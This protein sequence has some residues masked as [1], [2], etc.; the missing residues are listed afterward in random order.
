MDALLLTAEALRESINFYDTNCS[1]LAKLLIFLQKQTD[2]NQSR[3]DS[4]PYPKDLNIDLYLRNNIK[5]LNLIK[6][7]FN[8][9]FH[10]CIQNSWT[11]FTPETQ[12]SLNTI[13]EINNFHDSD[14]YKTYNYL[15]QETAKGTNTLP[16]YLF[17]LHQNKNG[18]TYEFIQDL[19][20][21]TDTSE[22]R[23]VLETHLLDLIRVRDI[24][25]LLLLE[26]EKFKKH[27]HEKYIPFLKQNSKFDVLNRF[28]NL[29][30]VSEFFGFEKPETLIGDQSQKKNYLKK[31]TQRP[32]TPL[33]KQHLNS[34]PEEEE[35]EEEEK[36][37]I[38]SSQ[39]SSFFSTLS[40]KSSTTEHDTDLAKVINSQ[41]PV[42]TDQ[43]SLFQQF[44]SRLPNLQLRNATS[45]PPFP[46]E[47]G[48]QLHPNDV[49]VVE[50]NKW[51]I[52]RLINKSRTEEL[53]NILETFLLAQHKERKYLRLKRVEAIVGKID[54][55]EKKQ[56]VEKAIQKYQV[57][58]PKKVVY[59]YQIQSRNSEEEV[60]LIQ[61]NVNNTEDISQLIES[62]LTSEGDID[63]IEVELL[64]A[65]FEKPTEVIVDEQR[66]KKPIQWPFHDRIL[67]RFDFAFQSVEKLLIENQRKKEKTRED[68]K[69]EERLKRLQKLLYNNKPVPI[70]QQEFKTGQQVNSRLNPFTPADETLKFVTNAYNTEPYRE[71]Q[72][73]IEPDTN[74]MQNGINAIFYKWLCDFLMA[75]KNLDRYLI[76]FNLLQKIADTNQY[77]TDSVAYKVLQVFLKDHNPNALKGGRNT[78]KKKRIH[79]TKKAGNK[80]NS[81]RLKKKPR[82]RFSRKKYEN[83]NVV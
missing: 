26:N 42:A 32:L 36:R 6:Y 68:Q 50:D 78:K 45:L 43:S 41:Q 21:S 8:V 79:K 48:I 19:K 40:S 80:M 77:S 15:L 55:A 61:I 71:Y 47:S 69:N 13:P 10:H 31:T 53:Q 18:E 72:R 30:F 35:E 67:I 56:I 2:K 83:R 7:L 1:E 54:N 64:K 28:F 66:G 70:S 5:D 38:V 27:I 57:A 16:S 60:K 82:T 39:P 76:R 22:K 33:L 51:F 34:V 23:I 52:M 17:R 81:T 25:I 65:I 74:K 14:G 63:D 49:T 46:I 4:L 9:K 20:E 75:T 12:G 37:D 3:L 11:T 73:E 44:T 29:P 62:F 58:P 24:A 59:T